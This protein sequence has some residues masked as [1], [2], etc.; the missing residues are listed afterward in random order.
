MAKMMER[1]AVKLDDFDLEAFKKWIEN[2][3]EGKPPNLGF[4]A[5]GSNKNGTSTSVW[6][7]NPMQPFLSISSSMLR[8]CDIWE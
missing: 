5:K 3:K 1:M 7:Q 2:G 6:M 4:P 8:S